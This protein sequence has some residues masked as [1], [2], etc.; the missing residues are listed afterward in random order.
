MIR[1]FYVTTALYILQNNF[2]FSFSLHLYHSLLG[3]A[4]RISSSLLSSLLRQSPPLYGWENWYPRRI[5][6]WLKIMQT[7]NRT[8]KTIHGSWLT[9]SM[10]LHIKAKHKSKDMSWGKSYSLETCKNIIWLL[11]AAHLHQGRW[12]TDIPET[13]CHWVISTTSWF[14]SLSPEPWG[15]PYTEHWVFYH[16][17]DR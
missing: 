7:V 9:H 11:K 10:L 2:I 8:E 5:S 3:G 16:N 1:T 15:W 17:R 4:R 13:P 12:V 14:H 6:N